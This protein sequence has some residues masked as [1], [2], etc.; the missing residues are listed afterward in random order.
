MSHVDPT[1]VRRHAQRLALLLPLLLGGCTWL[2]GA[3]PLRDAVP[4][5]TTWQ[6]ME[7]GGRTRRFVLHVPPAAARGPVPLVLAFHGYR[8]NGAVLRE[9]SGM[10]DAA[11]RRGVAVAYLDGTGPLGVVGL[12]W[13]A[14]TCCGRAQSDDVDDVAFSAAVVDRLASRGLVDRTRVWA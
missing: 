4:G 14:G 2:L 11:D 8:G 3:R 13:N 5:T 1:T 9:S 12:A 10:D 6:R 7:L